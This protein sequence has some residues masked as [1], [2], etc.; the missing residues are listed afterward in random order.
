MKNE[1]PYVMCYDYPKERK[2]CKRPCSQITRKEAA[3]HMLV[4]VE[5][6]IGVFYC[7]MGARRKEEKL[8]HIGLYE[9][10]NEQY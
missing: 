2:D 6:L 7:I 4:S 8:L 9:E 5:R 10:L 1:L 3:H